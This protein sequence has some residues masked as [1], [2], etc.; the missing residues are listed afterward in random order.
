[1][2]LPP[3]GTTEEDLMSLE[4]AAARQ[5]PPLPSPGDRTRVAGLTIRALEAEDCAAI[6]EL[7]AL[8]KVRWGTLRLPF[9]SREQTRKW[10]EA[11]ADVNTSIVAVLD[12]RL[13]G[14][15][16]VNR[17]TGRRRHVGGI[18]LCVHDDYCSRGIGS[19]LVGT[20]VDVADNWLDL[21][22]LELT[23]YV[24][25]EPAIRLYKKFGFVIEGTRR[26]DAFRGGVYADSYAMARIRIADA[27]KHD[28]PRSIAPVRPRESAKAGT[29][30]Q[31]AETSEQ[32]APGFPLARE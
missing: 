19:A 4:S 27:L 21:R 10:I 13:V 7:I 6:A 12:G 31:Q 2:A 24:D 1:M 11:K 15:A 18:G 28:E 3:G 26:A 25:N 8:P 16:G 30:G 17:F 32:A 9:S 29:Q 5:S 22:R 20:L 23:V 14:Q